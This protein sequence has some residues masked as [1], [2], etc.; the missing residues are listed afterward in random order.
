MPLFIL[1][2]AEYGL[3]VALQYEIRKNYVLVLLL[4]TLFDPI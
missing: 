4:L 2:K 1:Y 3:S